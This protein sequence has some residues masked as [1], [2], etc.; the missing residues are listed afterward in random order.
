MADSGTVALVTA[1]GDA[2]D[3]SDGSDQDGDSDTAGACVGADT[4]GWQDMVKHIAW[5]EVC[6]RVSRP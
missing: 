2:V 6:V 4:C 3:W 1:E 5:R